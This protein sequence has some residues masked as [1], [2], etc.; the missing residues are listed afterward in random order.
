M[1]LQI[2][3]DLSGTIFKT[4]TYKYIEILLDFLR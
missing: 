1:S 2:I 3:F 4:L